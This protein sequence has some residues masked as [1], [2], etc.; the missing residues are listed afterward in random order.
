[1][2]TATEQTA[3]QPTETNN[4]L[5][6][7]IS[8]L[9]PSSQWGSLNKIYLANVIQL[10]RKTISLANQPPLANKDLARRA[11]D[12]QDELEPNV[13]LDILVPAFRKACAEHDSSFPVNCF[14]I[15]AA[16]NKIKTERALNENAVKSQSP[17]E[18]PAIASCKILEKHVD[19]DRA[20][21]DEGLIE[22]Y[23]PADDST[24][25][26]PCYQCRP[27]AFGLRQAEYIESKK[28]AGPPKA[29]TDA[30]DAVLA[31]QKPKTKPIEDDGRELLGWCSKEFVQDY[32]N[33]EK[34][35]DETTTL[36]KFK[37]Q[38]FGK[39]W[40]VR[41]DE[42]EAQRTGTMIFHAQDYIK[43][44]PEGYAALKGVELPEEA[45]K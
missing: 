37:Y 38:L 22:L 3:M 45:A 33:A 31:S 34:S 24:R 29:V 7:Q 9:M 1:M 5:M 40:H 28:G 10:V 16:A 11:I 26:V 2:G 41:L 27:R 42:A 30:V 19:D 21:A 35:I 13:E 39:I 6:R 12:W 4:E 15:I 17:D 14:D 43:L 25:I 23:N 20:K 36:R 18:P 8:S 44:G 32:L